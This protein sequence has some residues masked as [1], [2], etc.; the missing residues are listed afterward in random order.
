MRVSRQHRT[1]RLREGLCGSAAAL[2][3]RRTWCRLSSGPG[4]HLLLRMPSLPTSQTGR[5]ATTGSLAADDAGGSDLHSTVRT[6][7]VG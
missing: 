1:G 7:S 2:L 5:D 4:Q 3:D 6:M